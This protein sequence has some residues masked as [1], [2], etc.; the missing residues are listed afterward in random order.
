ME[1]IEHSGK[2]AG[3]FALMSIRILVLMSK[4]KY[5][6]KKNISENSWKPSMTWN[7]HAKVIN[8]KKI[9]VRLPETDYWVMLHVKLSI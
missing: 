5:W 2:S 1:G 4:R 9:T 7:T 6:A 3:V 8:E